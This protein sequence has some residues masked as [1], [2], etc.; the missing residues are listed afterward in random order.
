MP[1]ARHPARYWLLL[2][3]IG[4]VGGLLSGMFAIG[5]G[6][7]LVPLLKAMVRMDHRRAV[8]T[9][10]LAIVPTAVVA[11][12]AYIANGEFDPVAAA[13]ISVG[14]IA[15]AL[16]GSALL[17][18]IPVLW[19]EWMFIALLV[20]IA[21]RLALV[22]PVRGDTVVFS[23][24]VAVAYVTLGLFIGV[25]SGLFGIGG[26]VLAVPALVVLFSMS[27]LVAKGTSLLVVLPTSVVGTVAN[28][29]A[30]LTDVRAGLAVGAAAAATSVL[31]VRIALAMSPRLSGVL[32]AALLLLVAAQLSWRAIVARRGADA[33]PPD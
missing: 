23:P 29:R 5:G 12:I 9:S 26:G 27:D 30:G 33:G 19:L 10:L 3:G 15:G 25:A 32:F 7:V 18:R 21:V 31:G 2:L 11:S 24:A 16:V 17:R 6:V 22:A 4:A 1:A 13:L 20:V 28:T 14:A 8:A